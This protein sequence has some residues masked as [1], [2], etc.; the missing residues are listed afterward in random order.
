MVPTE[1]HTLDW[2]SDEGSGF[3]SIHG[4]DIFVSVRG[5]PRRPG[6][7]V[8]ICEAG[9]GCTS[10][11]WSA[12]QLQAG[13]FVR[14]FAYD[15]AGMGRSQ[16]GPS[17]RKAAVAAQDLSDLL[18]SANISGP[19]VLVCHS[20]GGILAREFL[21]IRNDD[22]AGIIFV[23]TITERYSSDEPL[24]MAEFGAV[25]GNLDFWEISGL[26]KRQSLSAVDWE[27]SLKMWPRDRETFA[28]EAGAVTI[29]EQELAGK[30]QFDGQVMGNRPL[31]VIKGNATQEFV[32]VLNAGE[33]A[34]N[35]TASQRAILREYTKTS[36][37]TRERHQREQLKLS[38]NSRY[39]VAQHGY[40]SVQV[41]EPELV[42]AEIE[43]M[44]RRLESIGTA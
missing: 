23:D 25:L 24:P 41:S 29:S 33:A 16:P 9:R 17:P 43:T 1:A 28:A 21:H 36:E 31:V 10:Y 15:R 14:I 19:Y 20:Y 4:R 8:V 22:V 30:N 32:A 7:P 11:I 26:A 27:L 39:V 13:K 40:H 42:V 6:Q 37:A 18:D 5:P 38:T 3:V 35:G 2:N 34:G 44:L 12:V